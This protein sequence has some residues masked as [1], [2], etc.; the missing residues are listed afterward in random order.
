MSHHVRPR[1]GGKG[2]K[3]LRRGGARGK[4]HLGRIVDLTT[5]RPQAAGQVGVSAGM[6]RSGLQRATLWPSFLLGC[7]LAWPSGRA[8]EPDRSMATRVKM[9]LSSILST[10]A[11]HQGSRA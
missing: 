10:K 4:S 3:E 6:A 11:K 5:A 9:L 8:T 2:D 1:P 7:Q